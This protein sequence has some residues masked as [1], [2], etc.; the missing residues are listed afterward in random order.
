MICYIFGSLASIIGAQ[1]F[2]ADS[3]ASALINT[4]A[5]FA[6][7]IYCKTVWG[8][9]FWSFG[10]SYWKKIYFSINPRADGWFRPF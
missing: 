6:A 8:F 4:L 3:G 9:G 10:G 2:P 1:L 5:I 7:G